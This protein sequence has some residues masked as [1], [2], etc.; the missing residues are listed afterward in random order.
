MFIR[1]KVF[2]FRTRGQDL[3]PNYF[4]ASLPF[5][6]QDVVFTLAPNGKIDPFHRNLTI[7]F[8]DQD[9]ILPNTH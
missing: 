9:Y 2:L 7:L 4:N 8:Q 6:V 5:Q 3:C 1:G